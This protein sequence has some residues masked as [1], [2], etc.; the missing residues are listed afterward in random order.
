M[1]DANHFSLQKENENAQIKAQLSLYS[2][3]FFRFIA[4][5]GH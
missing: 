4:K 2:V 5:N 1:A 3:T